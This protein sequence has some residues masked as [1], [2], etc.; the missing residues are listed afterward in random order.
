MLD[1][2]ANYGT[3]SLYIANKIKNLNKG[4]KV[5]TFEIQPKMLD[6][7]KENIDLNNLNTYININHFGLGNN[8]GEMDLIIPNDYD[9]N[10]N[11]GG[12]SLYN[13]NLNEQNHKIKVSI[14][15]LDELS[16]SNI[17][18]IK[19]DVEGFELE[20]FEGGKETIINNKPVII[21]EI[22]ENNKDKYF[23]WIN[24]NFPFYNI[25]N[26]AGSDYRLIPK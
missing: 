10:E 17:S 16:L 13:N 3:H 25:E 1:I 14:K 22:W 9:L 15:K 6:L 18:V 23:D 24:N 26:I 19:I 2:G 7:L 12:I 5:Y 21:I 4:G 8:D 11:P 20:V